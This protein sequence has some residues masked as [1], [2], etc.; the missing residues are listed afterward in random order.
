V[1]VHKLLADLLGL[2]ETQEHKHKVATVLLTMAV[3]VEEATG[4]AQLQ[5]TQVLVA[6][7]DMLVE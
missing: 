7:V 5:P 2:A 1:V 4:V 6:V 3:A